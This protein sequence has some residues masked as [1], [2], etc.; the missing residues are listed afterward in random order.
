MLIAVVAAC[1]A[2]ALAA[3]FALILLC[4]GTRGEGSSRLLAR[5]LNSASRAPGT[6]VVTGSHAR[7]Y[8][9][10]AGLSGTGSAIP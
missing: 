6:R 10:R 4:R 9:A 3:V 5:V 7:I 8:P 1:V 2:L